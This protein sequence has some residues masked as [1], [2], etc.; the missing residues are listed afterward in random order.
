MLN[1]AAKQRTYNFTAAVTT[2][3]SVAALSKG[4]NMSLRPRVHSLRRSVL[5]LAALPL[6]VISS[7]GI[8]QKYTLTPVGN[9]G[10]QNSQGLISQAYGINNAGAVVGLAYDANSFQQA[11]FYSAGT[12]TQLLPRRDPTDPNPPDSIATAI[13]QQGAAVGWSNGGS[14]FNAVN[15]P[16]NPV[17]APTD[18]GSACLQGV[19]VDS[20]ANAINSN[21]D[22]AGL[23]LAAD[24]GSA[25]NDEHAALFSHGAVIDLHTLGTGTISQALGINDSGVIV[26]DSFFDASNNYHA[27]SWDSSRSPPMQDLGTFPGGQWS[28][29]YAINA[30]GVV[31]GYSDLPGVA[32]GHA[33]T[34]PPGGTMQDLTPG[35]VF[36]SHA[37]GINASGQIVGFMGMQKAGVEVEVPFLYSNGTINDLNSMIDPTDP[38]APY[39]TLTGNFGF[40]VL[41]PVSINDNGWIVAMG[42]DSRTGT[43]QAY[44]LIPNSAGA[45]TLAPTSLG[46]A[47]QP[48]STTSA[49][50][51][52]TLTSSGT[53]ALTISSITASAGFTLTTNCPLKPATLGP[54]A[55]CTINVA[56]SPTSAGPY[57]G[58]VT[59]VDD[60]PGS[61]QTVAL[62]GT[63]T[64]FSLAVAP[65]MQSVTPGK[66]VIYTVTATPLFGFTGS[67][68]LGCNVA[69]IVTAVGC[70]WSAAPLSLNG[71]NSASGSVFSSPSKKA[72]KGG[73]TILVSGSSGSLRETTTATLNVR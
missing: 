67:V 6:L 59:I 62:S 31:V 16:T 8:A 29:A 51:S 40:S 33:F 9:L 34:I 44:L 63:G 18:L 58:S 72:P 60:A 14:G 12:G 56:S 73:Y 26:G 24:C 10:G 42:T 7:P 1:K 21:G 48:R 45:V 36:E 5:M 38:L 20:K 30:S 52:I 27:F 69:P 53:A 28:H 25:T 57:T 41:I 55:P 64:D 71:V 49:T 13:N 39:V 35:S 68:V 43:Q 22:A 61:P 4:R 66:T 23:T 19:P 70:S 50:K 32:N 65:S 54:G 11:F 47:G 2:T 3:R 37:S 17:T 15:W 46:F